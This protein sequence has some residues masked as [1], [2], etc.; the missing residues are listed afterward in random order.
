V[1]CIPQRF[2][3]DNHAW[4]K[5]LS[6]AT[7][8]PALGQLLLSGRAQTSRHVHSACTISPIGKLR[9]SHH[10]AV[11]STEKSLSISRNTLCHCRLFLVSPS[12]TFSTH[13]PCGVAL[14]S[15]V[16]GCMSGFGHSDRSP[17]HMRDLRK[18]KFSSHFCC[19][20]AHGE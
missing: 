20:L 11:R 14:Q 3:S 2:L 5:N 12:I 6:R 16:I 10:A 1:H 7:I 15:F 8:Y 19:M 17:L 18:S 13:F 4:V 9:S